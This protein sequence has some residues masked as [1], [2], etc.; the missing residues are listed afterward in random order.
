MA[1]SHADHV[2]ALEKG[3]TQRAIVIVQKAANR[4]SVSAVADDVTEHS[5]QSFKIREC[6]TEPVVCKRQVK[7]QRI[8]PV[9]RPTRM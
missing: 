5:Q 8:S 2:F 1:Y 3:S 6:P 7:K 9:I 4:H